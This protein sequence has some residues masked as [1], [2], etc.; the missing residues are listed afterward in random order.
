M[1]GVDNIRASNFSAGSFQVENTGAKKISGI[2]IDVRGALYPDFGLRPRRRRRRQRHQALGDRLGREAP[3]PTST[4]TGYFLPGP[5]PLPNTTGTG[6]ASNGGFEGAMVKFNAGVSGGFQKGE[7]ATFSG[8]M[9][10]NSLAG[11]T[12][13]G[14]DSG[15]IQGW[16][17]GGVSGHELIGSDFIVLF[18]D[19]TTASGQVMSNR[20]VAAAHALATQASGG[21]AVNLSVNG[22]APGGTGTWGGTLPS[23]IV[24]A[25]PGETVRI[26]MTKGFNPVTNSANGIASLVAARLADDAFKANN[27]FDAQTV[28][29]LIGASG[30]FNASQLFD[31]DDLSPRITNVGSFA[32]DDVARIGFVASVIDLANGRVPKGSVTDPI[33]LTNNGG[34]VAHD[35]PDVN[36]FYKAITSGSATRFKVQFEDLNGPGGPVPP[37][38]WDFFNAPDAAGRQTG[39]QGPG[40]YVWGSELGSGVNSPTASSALTYT[41]FIPEGQGGNYQLRV[42]SSRD[43]AGHNDVWVKIDGNAET[44]QLNPANTVN[45]GPYVRLHG[46]PA[47]TWGFGQT[48]DAVSVADFPAVFKLGEGAH[49]ITFAGRSEGYHL[50][51]WELFKGSAPGVSVSNSP[52]QHGAPPELLI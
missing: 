51:Y 32:G 6:K 14:V 43:A 22:V 31:Y 1:D 41:I 38:K 11:L 47:D 4:G 45:S 25:D 5:N 23:V 16:D 17:V 33:Y 30:T 29:V 46:A 40:Y 24:T 9:D 8:D 12:K 35:P 37:G 13:S 21:E 10:P 52:F 34:P 27:A 20:N 19:G 44:L 36:G 48:L 28:D 15:A 50:D 42:R 39:F 26:T 18:D 7:I 2:F 3:A 49:T